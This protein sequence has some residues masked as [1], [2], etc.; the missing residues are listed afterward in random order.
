MPASESR[1]T[2]CDIRPGREKRGALFTGAA[3]SAAEL[4]TLPGVG[5]SKAQA[6]IAHREV[7]PFK[8]ADELMRNTPNFWEKYVRPKVRDD[9]DRLYTFLNHPFPDGPNHY[10]QRIEENVARL[11][12]GFAA[13]GGVAG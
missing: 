4:E 2:V 7:A 1:A 10:V 9:F 5:P 13:A 3:A 8:S 6:I 12:T 11:R